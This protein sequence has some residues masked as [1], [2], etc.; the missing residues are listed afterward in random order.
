[1][2]RGGIAIRANDVVVGGLRFH[3]RGEGRRAIVVV[4]GAR[5]SLLRNEIVGNQLVRW[6]PCVLLDGAAGTTV[7]GNV[8]SQCTSATSQSV[9]SQG[10][11]VVGSSGTTIANNVV[12]RTPGDGIAFTRSRGA[13]VVRNHVH[14]N[15]NGVYLGPDTTDVI[16][17]DNVVAYSGRYGV[18]GAGGFGNLVTGNCL[19]RPGV[20]NVSGSGFVAT[21][22]R[23]TSPRYVNRHRSLAMRRGPCARLRPRSRRSA[24]RSVGTPFPVL[25]RF[26]VHYRLL[27]LP[28]SVRF[29]RVFLTRVLPGTPVSARCVR[30]CSAS[31]R[32][33]SSGDGRA[34]HPTAATLASAR[35][36]GRDP[37][38]ASGLGRARRARSRRRPAARRRRR[39]L[40]HGRRSASAR[41]V[42]AAGEA[43][44][45][46]PAMHAGF[47][48]AITRRQA[49]PSLLPRLPALAA[50]E[51]GPWLGARDPEARQH[52]RKRH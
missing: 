15:T 39:P 49:P 48:P 50:S 18:L 4:Q 32:S 23:F 30:R 19:W 46:L 40:V 5:V 36:R 47:W 8:I 16:V 24:G 38:R 12:E 42:R 20:G 45:P 1:M 52:P 6:T 17:A 13:V 7:D 31:A 9:H 33:A 21:A 14:G 22:N 11:F 2:L 25:P 51:C 28:R 29:E 35:R 44:V 43:V 34:L 37:S 26:V 10:I 3:G 27:A 41:R